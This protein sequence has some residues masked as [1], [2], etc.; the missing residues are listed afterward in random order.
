MTL[1][2]PHPGAISA[3]RRTKETADQCRA[4]AALVAQQTERRNGLHPTAISQLSF[5]R[6]EAAT[7]TVIY[8]DYEP[9]LAM[10]VQGK[11]DLFLGEETYSYGAGQYLV[12]SVDLPLGGCVVEAASDKPY[13]ALK[14]ALDPMQLCDLVTQMDVSSKKQESSGRGL[15]IGRADTTLLESV[16]RLTKLL[17]TP[18]DIP[19][20]APMMIREIYYRLLMGEQGEAVRQIATSGSTM[21]RI[22]EAIKRIKAEFTQPMR[23]EDL[24]RQVGM[25][26][27]AFHQHF[28][29]VTAMSP[30]QYQ[31]QLRLLEARRLMLVEGFDATSAAYQVGY[32]SSSQFSREYSRL[33]GAP[34]MRDIERLR[35]A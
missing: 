6:A 32:E 24:A 11:K 16:F 4:L 18:Q 10:I 7:S 15:S 19:I 26:T 25:S 30:L 5:A 3:K 21:Q 34:P 14:L 20:L 33:F 17:D 12:V 35:T 27:S 28:K 1:E 2:I 29:Q 13:L 22:S 23:I 31:K 9:R 8:Q